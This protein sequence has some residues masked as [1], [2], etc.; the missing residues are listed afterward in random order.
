MSRAE[1]GLG[2]LETSLRI[3]PLNIQKAFKLLH[4]L[5]SYHKVQTNLI[6]CVKLVMELQIM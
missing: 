6:Y 1:F 2:F 5:S 3:Y 4:Y